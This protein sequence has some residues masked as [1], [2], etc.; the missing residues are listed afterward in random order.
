MCLP[1]LPG[2]LGLPFIDGPHR[3]S[4]PAWNRLITFFQPRSLSCRPTAIVD[5]S[6]PQTSASLGK[7]DGSDF[8]FRSSSSFLSFADADPPRC[9]FRPFSFIYKMSTARPISPPQ[10]PPLQSSALPVGRARFAISSSSPCPVPPSLHRFLDKPLSPER[11]TRAPL[12]PSTSTRMTSLTRLEKPD[13]AGPSS[14][15]EGSSPADEWKE[16]VDGN[17]L[18]LTWGNVVE[19][20]EPYEGHSSLAT[21]TPAEVSFGP[22]PSISAVDPFASPPILP[23]SPV[24][25]FHYCTSRPTQTYSGYSPVFRSLPNVERPSATISPAAFVDKRRP[26]LPHFQSDPNFSRSRSKTQHTVPET[27]GRTSPEFAMPFLP[28]RI[29]SAHPSPSFMLRPLSPFDESPLRCF[30]QAEVEYPSTPP[31]Q[32]SSFPPPITA[33]P[34]TSVLYASSPMSSFS[35]LSLSPDAPKPPNHQRDQF[36]P[37]SLRDSPPSATNA[38]LFDSSLGISPSSS[39]SSPNSSSTRVLASLVPAPDLS[40][41]SG[42]FAAARADTSK[43]GLGLAGAFSPPVSL[44]YVP[45]GDDKTGTTLLGHLDTPQPSPEMKR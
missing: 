43:R 20:D 11:T 27:R 12:S 28:S 23:T 33:S 42:S 8:R 4:L 18:G 24:L 25:S 41:P 39:S 1:L 37:P 35:R 14:Q 26:S 17:S 22:S 15:P 34:T 3:S 45:D 2:Y 40:S 9:S 38:I 6:S 10:V 30:G 32:I 21:R 19:V 29:L 16:A 7:S 44:I 5:P 36:P 13:P 31:D